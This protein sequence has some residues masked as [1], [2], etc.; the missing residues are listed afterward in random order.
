MMVEELLGI[1][2]RKSKISVMLSWFTQ[3]TFG[4]RSLLFY[5]VSNFP[6]CDWYQLETVVI[7]TVLCGFCLFCC[8]PHKRY[9]R[10][11]LPESELPDSE[12]SLRFRTATKN[13][14]CKAR[15][16]SLLKTCRVNNLRVASI[17]GSK[18][19]WAGW[20]KGVGGWFWCLTLFRSSQ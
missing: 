7:S 10:T 13:T 20:G 2:D 8:P 16:P 4:S 14:I 5:L 3:L 11:W 12:G 6:P 9:F 15:G 19:R 17:F 1:L 18:T